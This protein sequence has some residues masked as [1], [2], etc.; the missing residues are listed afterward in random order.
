[1]GRAALGIVGAGLGQAEGSIHR[2]P[3]FRGVAVLLAII[4]PPADGAQDQRLG[5]FQR[6]VSATWATKT[7]HHSYP[8]V[9]GRQQQPAGLHERQVQQSVVKAMF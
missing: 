9:D 3:D 1:M 6:L 8:Y 5:R 2:Q 4:L 7:G